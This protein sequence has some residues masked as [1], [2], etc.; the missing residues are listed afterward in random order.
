MRTNRHIY[1]Y[2]YEKQQK[3]GN[4]IMEVVFNLEL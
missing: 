1:L 3:Q 2:V 4:S